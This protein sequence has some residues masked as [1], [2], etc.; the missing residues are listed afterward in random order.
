MLSSE[1]GRFRLIN[2][3]EGL[4]FL[5]LLFIA[6]PL[7][8][9]ADMPMAVRYPGMAHGVLFVLFVMMLLQVAVTNKWKLFFT[10]SLLIAT[11]IPFAPFFCDKKI[12]AMEEAEH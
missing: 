4:S 6:M 2:I 5:L 1:I 8:Y 7:K 10:F 12:K 11:L 9:F 3:L